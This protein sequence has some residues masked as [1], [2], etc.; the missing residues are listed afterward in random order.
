VAEAYTL[1]VSTA[2]DRHLA[3]VEHAAQVVAGVSRSN[4][5]T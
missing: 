5:A 1:L 4:S 2:A 3:V